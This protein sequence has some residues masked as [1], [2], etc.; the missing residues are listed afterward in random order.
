MD[1]RVVVGV[2]IVDGGRVLAAL[3]PGPDGGW[4]FPGGKVEPGES[5]EVAAAREIEEELG[6]RII[7]GAALP[8]EELI[9]DKYVLRVYLAEPAGHD[10]LPVLREH[11]EIRWVQAADLGTLG[12]LPA[13]RPFLATLGHHL[14]A[15]G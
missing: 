1:R 9:G 6:L 12:W 14:V 4:E 13:D 11:T 7:V 8:G 5:D 10:W 2:A 3:R 15:D